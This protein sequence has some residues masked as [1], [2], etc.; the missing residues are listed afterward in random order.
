MWKKRSIW[1]QFSGVHLSCSL[2]LIRK[3]RSICLF[4]C[5]TQLCKESF[6]RW[7]VQL[8]TW[9]VWSHTFEQLK[10]RCLKCPA[11][12][13]WSACHLPLL[14]VFNYVITSLSLIIP[15]T[16]FSHWRGGCKIQ[17]GLVEGRRAC[18]DWPW[19][20]PEVQSYVGNMTE[21][22]RR[23]WRLRFY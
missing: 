6:F 8:I 14:T 20:V 18:S 7:E 2:A 10:C 22:Q 11:N 5:I 19:W 3:H 9:K 13:Q 1:F 15:F 21:R 4:G 17:H 23:I 12:L 16:G